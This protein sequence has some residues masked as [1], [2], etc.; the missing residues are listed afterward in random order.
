VCLDA[1]DVVRDELTILC[2]KIEEQLIVGEI[3]TI[4]LAVRL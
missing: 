3:R 4:S 2:K 1:E